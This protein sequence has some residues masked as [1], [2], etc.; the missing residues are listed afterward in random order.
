MAMS[1]CR[2]AVGFAVL[3]FCISLETGSA[4]GLGREVDEEY[5]L[6]E[7]EASIQMNHI[8][9]RHARLLLEDA[10]PQI[11]ERESSDRTGADHR[12]QGEALSDR[13]RIIAV[14]CVVIVLAVLTTCCCLKRKVTGRKESSGGLSDTFTC[15]LSEATSD[16]CLVKNQKDKSDII[17]RLHSWGDLS[18]TAVKGSVRRSDDFVILVSIMAPPNTSPRPLAE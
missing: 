9:S 7:S 15:P 14:C 11:V 18:P 4:R 17:D 5:N 6:A 8:F 12:G 3:V 10:S 2:F 1:T 16:I 13:T